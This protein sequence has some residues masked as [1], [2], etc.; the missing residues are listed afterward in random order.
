[1]RRSHLF[2]PGV[3]S[4]LLLAILLRGRLAVLPRVGVLAWVAAVL[5]VS[6]GQAR[7]GQR[8]DAAALP[9]VF[10]TMH[11][12]WGLG[13]IAGSVRWGPPTAAVLRLLGPKT[14]S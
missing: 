8:G 4:A 12:S 6:A 14:G 11:L 1:M 9:L 7:P 2:A 5:G 13:F 3:V 10:A